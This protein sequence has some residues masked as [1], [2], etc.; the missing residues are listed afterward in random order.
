[1]ATRINLEVDIKGPFFQGDYTRELHKHLDEAK[2]DIAQ[3]GVNRIQERIGARAKN[4]SGYYAG[5]VVTDVVKPFND[6]IIELSG[7]AVAYGPWI[8][9]T[10]SRNSTT[11]YKGYRIFRQVRSWL[12]KAATPIAQ[13]KIDQFVNRMNGGG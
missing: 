13:A 2:A 11:R 4:P 10:S 6:Q 7:R 1:M 9:G 8:E 3:M 12:R 5:H